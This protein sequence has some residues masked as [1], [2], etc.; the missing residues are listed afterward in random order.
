[1][2]VSFF[3][4]SINHNYDIPYEMLAYIYEKLNLEVMKATYRYYF[5]KFSEKQFEKEK[6][7]PYHNF[8]PVYSNIVK[9]T[10]SVQ[11]DQVPLVV[12]N[13]VSE[14]TLCQK[15]ALKIMPHLFLKKLVGF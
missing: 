11:A 7:Y 15:T 5:L 13:V 3:A 1:M 4:D 9:F 6:I 12:D 10:G 8:F 2:I 14:F